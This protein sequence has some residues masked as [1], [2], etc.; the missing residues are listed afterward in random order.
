MQEAPF[1]LGRATPSPAVFLS[2]PA[3]PLSLSSGTAGESKDPEECR[4]SWMPIQGVLTIIQEPYRRQ[5]TFSA[6]ADRRNLRISLDGMKIPFSSLAIPSTL[7]QK[8]GASG[9]PVVAA[10]KQWPHSEM[11]VAF[12]VSVGRAAP[13]VD[14]ATYVKLTKGERT[15]CQSSSNRRNK[16]SNWNTRET[17]LPLG[18]IRPACF[19]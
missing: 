14:M 13:G 16:K 10:L 7:R 6:H 1:T 5:L 8:G 2:G 19:Q 15:K 17:T 12:R 4:L 11:G 3:G 18:G 9:A